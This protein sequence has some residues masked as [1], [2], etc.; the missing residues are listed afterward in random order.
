MALLFTT[1]MTVDV[2]KFIAKFTKKYT[3]WGGIVTPELETTWKLNCQI[4]NHTINNPTKV[5]KYVVSAPTGSAKTE[6]LITY[7]SMLPDGVT[8]LISTNLTDD[9]DEIAAKINNEKGKVFACS[10][11]SKN[12][13]NL[14]TAATYPVVVTTHEF[15]KKHYAGTPEWDFMVDNRNLLVIDEALDTMKELSVEDTAIARAILIFSHIQKWKK[16]KNMPRFSKELQYLK[17]DLKT[18]NDSKAGTNLIRS[19]KI[20]KLT[21]GS[22]ILSIEFDKYKI[23][24]EILGAE[25]MDGEKNTSLNKLGK[26]LKYS[27]I[28]TGINDESIN[29]MIKQEL[30]E[31]IDNLN[32]LKNRQVYITAN[33]GNKSFNRVTDMMFKKP[34][35]CFDATSTVNKVYSLREQYHKDIDRVEQVKNIRNYKN[36]SL[37]KIIDKTGKDN[38]D[39]N[40]ATN[41]LSSVKLG[42]KTL[43]VTHKKNESF[44]E[45]VKEDMY[46]SKTIEVAHWNAITGKNQ[47]HDF[48]TCIIAGLNHKPEFYAQNRVII[49]T[50]TE[51]TAFG[52]I[53]NPLKNAIAD[54]AMIAEIIQA[55][56]RI[57]IRKVIDDK[58]NCD[59]ANIYVMLPQYKDMAFV[60]DIKKEMP[61]IKIKEWKLKS[62]TAIKEG[63]SHFDV[64][65]KY[66]VNNLK[67]GDKIYINTVRDKLKIKDDSY[68]TMV[69]KT[70]GEKQ[71]FKNKL[72]DYGIEIIEQSDGSRGRERKKYPKRYYS[73]IG[74]SS[75]DIY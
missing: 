62:A 15:Y 6:N 7:C 75:N 68:R 24:S 12:D 39:K 14:L 8:A 54:S 16:F 31:T 20:W 46:P 57:R 72:Y 49:N 30:K 13:V 19:D 33:I 58:G 52:V 37:H 43:I 26:A 67:D 66:L 41:I 50:D 4:L 47:W 71:E 28:L 45:Q 59:K 61:H 55:I 56:N 27:Y 38:I 32:Q 70:E 42:N 5:M 69:G 9:A 53:Q 51:T 65:V 17:D 29:K 48:D 34:L 36:V 63:K 22:K 10:F 3:G 35:V 74:F 1:P 21:G 73:K 23:F 64:V 18:L 2:T 44:F 60:R 11:H 40:V 25:N